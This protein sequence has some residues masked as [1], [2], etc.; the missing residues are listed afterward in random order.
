MTNVR[1]LARFI[2]HSSLVNRHSSIGMAGYSGTPLVKKL[3]I[4]EGFRVAFVNAPE[5]FMEQLGPLPERVTLAETAG[6]SVDLILLFA[7]EGAELEKSFSKLSQRLSPAGMLWVAWPKKGSTYATDLSFAAVQ[8]TGLQAG[9]VDVKICAVDDTWSGL[10]FV[11]RV[12][13]RGNRSAGRSD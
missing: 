5:N 6:E 11:I 3:G 7:R 1:W 4:K 13:D 8:H 12:K 9:L 2:R 10:K